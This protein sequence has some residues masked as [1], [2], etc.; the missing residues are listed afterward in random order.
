MDRKLLKILIYTTIKNTSFKRFPLKGIFNKTVTL[1]QPR[2]DHLSWLLSIP[3]PNQMVFDGKPSICKKC[4][5]ITD[6]SQ[7]IFTLLYQ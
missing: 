5:T 4:A 1:N 6:V 2:S 7:A 3:V